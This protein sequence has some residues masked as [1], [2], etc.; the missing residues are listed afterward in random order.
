MS[1]KIAIL[2]SGRGSNAQSIFDNMKCGKLDIDLVLVISNKPN[3]EVLKRAQDANIP[4]LELDHKNYA[5]RKEFD[6]VMVNALQK[7]GAELIVLAGYMRILTTYFLNS[8]SGKVINIHPAILPAF[9]GAHGIADAY[10]SRVKLTGCTVHFVSE[11]LDSGAIIIQAAI[12]VLTEEPLEELEK[13]MHKIEH[14][15]YPQAIQ[16]LAQNRIKLINE[17]VHFTPANTKNKDTT[18]CINNANS[19]LIWPPLEDNF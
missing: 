16:W 4:T 5:S 15:I 8:F 6:T 14:Q 18:I 12:P 11:E 10:N 1:L 3:S 2:A 17:Q 13:R 9:K 7:A 19:Y